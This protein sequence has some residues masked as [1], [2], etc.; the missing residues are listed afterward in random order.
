MARRRGKSSRGQRDTSDIASPNRELD[1]VLL[2]P[3]RLT[4][5]SIPDLSPLPD[6]FDDRRMWHPDSPFHP[7]MSMLGPLPAEIVEAPSRAPSRRPGARPAAR[8]GYKYPAYSMPS[9]VAVCVRRNDRREVLF[10]KKKMGR[11][12]GRRRRNEQSKI[13]C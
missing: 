13:R 7:S 6:S 12:G 2:T 11:G 4:M 3:V 8:P 9:K 1:R 5:P 10:A